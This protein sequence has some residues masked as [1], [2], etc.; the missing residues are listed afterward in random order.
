VISTII[1]TSKCSVAPTVL[2]HCIFVVAQRNLTSVRKCPGKSIL[3]S[4]GNA[5]SMKRKLC[6]RMTM[7]ASENQRLHA[8]ME[9][10]QQNT[11]ALARDVDDAKAYLALCVADS[12]VTSHKLDSTE[13]DL[14]NA[15]TQNQQLLEETEQCQQE[16]AAFV[17]FT[18]D[19]KTAFETCQ[20]DLT[21]ATR[22]N[23]TCKK[24]LMESTAVKNELWIRHDS[25]IVLARDTKRRYERLEME[26]MRL[27]EE[28]DQIEATK[29]RGLPRPLRRVW[30]VVAP[31]RFHVGDCTDLTNTRFC[32]GD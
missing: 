6:A 29:R 27:S 31:K 18:R 20:A 10:C 24:A 22:D 25:C 7:L 1:A 17:A 14:K 13:K 12:R 16:A 26:N 9:L 23:R 3:A 28:L 19:T 32:V 4:R 30:N 11:T 15:Q 21:S 5:G 2:L 8:D